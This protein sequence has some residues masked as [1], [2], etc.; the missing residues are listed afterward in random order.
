MEKSR[1]FL[2][3]L[4]FIALLGLLGVFTIVLADVQFGFR[5]TMTIVFD[6]IA[7]LEPGHSVRVDGVRC[8]RVK[9]IART[10]HNYQIEVTVEFD[11]APRLWF[12]ATFEIKSATMLGGRVLEITN[13]APEERKEEISAKLKPHGEVSKDPFAQA[14]KLLSDENIA[15]VQKTIE[16]L[17]SASAQAREFFSEKVITDAQ[18]I[19]SQFEEAS[20]GARDLLAD[21]NVAKLEN[22]VT[23]IESTSKWLDEDGQKTLAEIREVVADVKAFTPALEEK[24]TAALE[25]IALAAAEARGLVADLRQVTARINPDEGLGKLLVDNEPWERLALAIASVEGA[26][27]NVE[28]AT[29]QLKSEDNIVGLLLTDEDMAKQLKRAMKALNDFLESTREDA[30]LTSF[31]GLL[32]TPF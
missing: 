26:A 21:E 20:R 31:A 1:D 23:R 14:S 28:I 4:V 32:L 15:K 9:E 10:A 25:D 6:T 8:G 7:G 27:K 22:A 11:A 16:H 2:T 17:E 5:P 30:P 12:G 19:V 18:L 29:G 24:G 3:G 13:P